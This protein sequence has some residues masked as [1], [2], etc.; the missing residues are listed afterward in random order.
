MYDEVLVDNKLVVNDG[1]NQH[2]YA[3]IPSKDGM[4][5]LLFHF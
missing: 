4:Q 3:A 2:I 1:N 5:V